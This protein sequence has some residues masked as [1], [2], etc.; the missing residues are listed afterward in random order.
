M[1]APPAVGGI[2]IPGRAEADGLY[3]LVD[4]LLA[5]ETGSAVPQ[6]QFI[7]RVVVLPCVL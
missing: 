3:T 2:Q 5:T 6:T 4:F 7:D 1:G